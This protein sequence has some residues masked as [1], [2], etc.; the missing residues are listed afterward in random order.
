MFYRLK[1]LKE[2]EREQEE[3]KGETIRTQ[4]LKTL[5][6]KSNKHV[7]FSSHTHLGIKLREEIVPR[8]MIIIVVVMVMV[9]VMV[10]VTVTVSL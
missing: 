3:E 4:L 5:K 9:M 7:I 8:F 6:S 1:T 10:R 2:R